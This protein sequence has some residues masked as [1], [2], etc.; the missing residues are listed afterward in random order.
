[1]V[2]AGEYSEYRCRHE[3]Q[4]SKSLIRGSN[5]RPPRNISAWDAARCI[6]TPNIRR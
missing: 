3:K 4:R 5:I 6:V 2:H 1:M